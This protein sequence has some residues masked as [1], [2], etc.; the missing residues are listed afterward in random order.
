MDVKDKSISEKNKF[1]QIYILESE[2]VLRDGNSA[3][4]SLQENEDN[5]V[6]E[7]EAEEQDFSKFFE[8]SV[9][10]QKI[11]LVFSDNIFIKQ[12]NNYPVEMI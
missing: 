4:S 11:S 2:E 8:S 7:V 9:N 12:E 6:E 5:V 1:I 3:A 10:S